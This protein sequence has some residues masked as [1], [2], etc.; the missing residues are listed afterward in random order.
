MC[1]YVCVYVCMY[2][3]MYLYVCVCTLYVCMYVFV[4][5]YIYFF[6]YLF[7]TYASTYV[8]IYV[9]RYMTPRSQLSRHSAAVQHSLGQLPVTTVTESSQKVP[10]F[11]PNLPSRRSARTHCPAALQY[12][13]DLTLCTVQSVNPCCYSTPKVRYCTRM[14]QITSYLW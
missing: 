13:S 5:V 4:Y 9:G 6:V 7:I 10:I 2:V 12:P 3:S 11:R 1:M 14:D 8:C